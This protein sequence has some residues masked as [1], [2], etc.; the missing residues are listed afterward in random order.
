[1]DA[2]RFCVNC[3]HYAKGKPVDCLAAENTRVDLVSGERVVAA[4]A[5]ISRAMDITGCG[6]AGKWWT[7]KVPA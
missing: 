7:A 2:P 4:Q 5:M 6:A 3:A 1:M